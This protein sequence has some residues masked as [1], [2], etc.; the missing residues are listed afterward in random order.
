[1]IATNTFSD[2]F[3]VTIYHDCEVWAKTVVAEYRRLQ[4]DE[5]RRG[6]AANWLATQIAS[7]AKRMVQE[8]RIDR[9]HESAVRRLKD[10]R[11]QHR[12]HFAVIMLLLTLEAPDLFSRSSR[13]RLAHRAQAML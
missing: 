1:M 8:G 6:D 9:I 12:S 2:R 7:F 5:I 11:V 4:A 3:Q 10:V 13:H